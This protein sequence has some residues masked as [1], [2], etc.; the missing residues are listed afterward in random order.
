MHK[1]QQRIAVTY[2]VIQLSLSRAEGGRNIQLQISD[3]GCGIPPDVLNK[4]YE[5]YFTTGSEADN[6]GLGLFMVRGIVTRM[7]GEIECESEIGK[8]TVFTFTITLPA[9][10][11]NAQT[12]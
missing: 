2:G 4:I 7:S 10:E 8:G 3:N 6:A 11:Y 12:G 5:P 9:V 1:S